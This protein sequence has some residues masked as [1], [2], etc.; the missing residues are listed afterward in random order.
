MRGA[1]VGVG[2]GGA[3]AR[4]SESLVTRFPGTTTAGKVSIG[5]VVDSSLRLDVRAG[6]MSCVSCAPQHVAGSRVT[7][8]VGACRDIA[9]S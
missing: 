5:E 3:P 7:R 2:G 1:R 6:R 9:P 4:G 8:G